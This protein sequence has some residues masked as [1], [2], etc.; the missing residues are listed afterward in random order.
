MTYQDG[1]YLEKRIV[2][3]RLSGVVMLE[4]AEAARNGPP[5]C[6]KQR[7]RWYM[8]SLMFPRYRNFPRICQHSAAWQ[9]I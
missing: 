3:Q 4:E 9:R 8:S 5:I 6:W 1:W 2:L 7:Y